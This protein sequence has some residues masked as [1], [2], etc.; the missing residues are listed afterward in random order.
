MNENKKPTTITV[1][2]PEE[3]KTYLNEIVWQNRTT[4]TAYITKLIEEDMEKHP[5]WKKSLDALSK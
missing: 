3:C 5:D 2:I 1:K 4:L